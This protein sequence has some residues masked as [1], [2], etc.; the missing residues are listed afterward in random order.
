VLLRSGACNEGRQSGLV[1]R[2]GG[3]AAP[4]A[5]ML[6]VSGCNQGPS[7]IEAPDWD[8]PALAERIV[9]ELDENG[10]AHVDGQEWTAAPGLAA[11]A[12]FIDNDKDG[13]LSREELE[14]RFQLYRELRVGLRSRPFRVTYKGR[15]VPDADTLFLPEP[16]L[17]GVIEPAR[18]TTDQQGTITPQAD[19]QDLL[20]MRVGYYRVQ[21]TSPQGSIPKKYSDSATTLGADVSLAEDAA[22][23]GVTELQLTD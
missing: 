3:L 19:G 10:D 9:S 4:C 12:R 11:G 7:R 23:Y 22:S 13:R 8:P 5:A 18:G 21:V 14:A 6:L 20:G 15:P 2:A 17:E 1:R 16:F